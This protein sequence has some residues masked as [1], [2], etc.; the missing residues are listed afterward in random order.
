MN[1]YIKYLVEAFDFNSVK[2]QNK[3]VNAVDAVLKYIIPKI[4]NREKLS[5]DDY[6]LLKNLVGIYK[7]SEKK[8]LKDLID[9]F[10]EQFGNECNLN[11]IDV[12][13]V[14]NMGDMF[15]ASK[16]NGDISQWNVSNVTDMPSMFMFSKFNGNIS[17]WNVSNV[18]NMASMFYKSV[19]DG[20]ISKWDVSN[21]INMCGMFTHSAFKQDISNWKINHNC[22]IKEI[23]S[24]CPIPIKY[25]PK[26]H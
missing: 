10:I 8:E 24:S 11:W 19:F 4:D 2:K 14:T 9:Y 7:V 5:Q 17:Q 16:F 3:K 18:I 6:D 1:N 22:N 20:D 21:V 25:Q 26:L 15:Y 12:S 13:N 23:F